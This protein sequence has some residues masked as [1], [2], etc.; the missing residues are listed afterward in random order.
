M[1]TRF[2]SR[3]YIFKFSHGLLD[4]FPVFPGLF[5]LVCTCFNILKIAYLVFGF[6]ENP[7]GEWHLSEK[8]NNSVIL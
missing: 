5:T 1:I 2:P 7:E 8:S 4:S 6:V 3:Q